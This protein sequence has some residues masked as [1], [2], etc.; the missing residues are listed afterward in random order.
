MN[1]AQISIT[2]YIATQPQ[3]REVRPGVKKLTMRVA[4][5]PRHWDRAS[6]DWADGH[7]SFVSVIC[8]RKLAENTATC[9]RKG[10]PVVIKGKFS[11]RDF[12]DK[13]GERRTA[14]EVEAESVGHDLARGVAQFQ[15]TRPQTGL[16][17][18]EFEKAKEAEGADAAAAGQPTGADGTDAGPEEVAG[19]AAGEDGIPVGDEMFDQD[20]VSDLAQQ[21]ETAV[22]PF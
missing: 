3:S 12:E 2:G 16:T 9:L 1:E 5:T 22:A 10:D 14:Y 13:N 4:W 19:G 11:S 17:A 6:G 20:A 8:W 15:R 21:P 18:A 7:T